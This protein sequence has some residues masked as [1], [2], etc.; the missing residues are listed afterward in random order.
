MVTI[1]LPPVISAILLTLTFMTH[2][3]EHDSNSSICL[4]FPIKSVLR[5]EVNKV[6][7]LLEKFDSFV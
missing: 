3:Q 6:E 4:I 1:G 5:G 7:N 2:E